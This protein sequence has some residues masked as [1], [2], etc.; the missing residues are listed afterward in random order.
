MSDRIT[1]L[2]P[3][4]TGALHLGNARTFLINWALARQHGWHIEMRI[5]DIDG[6]RIKPGAI[7]NTFD[8][9]QWLGIDWDGQPLIQ[10]ED[11]SPYRAAMQ[12]LAAQHR[13]FVCELSRKE[14]AAAATAPHADDHDQRF[15]P[16]LRP[17]TA[18][19]IRWQ[20]SAEDTNYRLIVSP[21]ATSQVVIDDAIAGQHIVDVASEIG[22]FVI[23]TKRSQP[24]YQLA[25]V[26][27]DMRQGVT[28]VVRGHDL[29]SS[30]GRQT[31]LY[32]ALDAQ[33]PRWWHVALVRGED[34]RR[35]A[36]RHGDTRLSTYREA[37]VEA[38]RIIALLARWSGIANVPAAMTAVQ[39]A[40]QFAL[41]HLSR[42]EVTF[43][44][45][46]HQWLLQK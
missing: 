24:S 39:F 45:E 7:E 2:A 38:D 19:T 36:K 10:S 30:A 14:I 22:D 41:E 44:K 33:P 13:V 18:D 46:D 12:T 6:P 43:T 1:R 17:S 23:W 28:D 21:D 3:S 29:I 25:V 4:P 27:D 31:L 32:Q 35:L 5:E 37:G 8:I 26:V 9:L 34:G 40:E 42:S 11:L 15:P 20:F 16:E